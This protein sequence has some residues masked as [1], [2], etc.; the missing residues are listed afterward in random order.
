[1]KAKYIS[2]LTAIAAT[3][4]LASCAKDLNPGKV[5]T[6][7]PG[8]SLRTIT[9]SFDAPTKSSLNKVD[10]VWAASFNLRDS[11]LVSNGEKLD[12]CEVEPG[13]TKKNMVINT[14]LVGPLHAVYPYT[15]AQLN[16]NE[17]TGV[18]VPSVQSGTFADANICEA[19]QSE[20]GEGLLSFRTKVAIL[21]FYKRDIGIEELRIN[22]KGE[23]KTI[24]TD[25]GS[26]RQII[27]KPAADTMLFNNPGHNSEY[28]PDFYF[29]A[30]KVSDEVNV[31][32]NELSFESVTSTQDL[33]VVKKSTSETN[34][35]GNTIYNVFIP[36]YI[37]VSV[38]TVDDPDT[39]RWGYCNVGAFTPDE[40]GDYFMWGEV[41]GH[42]Y[43][44]GE[45]TNFP[46]GCP[47]SNRYN[48]TCWVGPSG[49]CIGN[50]PFYS[51]SSAAYT[52]YN[53]E[54]GNT[55]LESADDAAS[56][57]WGE[58]WR[59]P[60]KEELKKLFGKYN[61]FGSLTEAGLIFPETYSFD[62]FDPEPDENM[63]YW[64]NEVS[65]EENFRQAYYWEIGQ[66]E[67]DAQHF[68]RYCGYSIR[69]IYDKTCLVTVTKYNDGG[70]L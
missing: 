11:I 40:P 51:G 57:N 67:E 41:K 43:V 16:G 70:T 17:I 9:V 62:G 12:T 3:A 1:M 65:N 69:P 60:T 27:I 56:S 58:D 4:A 66:L 5:D 48:S 49:F 22:I 15:A 64:S 29:A 31:Q 26:Q 24:S 42:K 35:V 46:S 2:I 38:G 19:D 44:N 50:A 59:M 52:K 68:D 32:G 36:Y 14:K 39:L 34:L 53:D 54:A 7:K 55:N 8:E 47:D 13:G 21:R 33:P 10:G 63:R 6:G 61:N 25:I 37:K 30:I 20:S 45:F 18:L 23:E 28:D